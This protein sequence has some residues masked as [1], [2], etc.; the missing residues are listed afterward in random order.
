MEA[1]AKNNNKKIALEFNAAVGDNFSVKIA[2][3]DISVIEN[4]VI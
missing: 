3:E 1:K 4:F 2:L